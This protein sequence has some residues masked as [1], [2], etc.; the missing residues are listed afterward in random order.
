VNGVLQSEPQNTPAY[1]LRGEIFAKK[2]LWD[3]AE[4]DYRTVVQLGGDNAQIKFNLAEPMV[5]TIAAK[6]KTLNPSITNLLHWRSL[7]QS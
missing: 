6:S 1:S 2:K 3:Q 7:I 4:K 5:S